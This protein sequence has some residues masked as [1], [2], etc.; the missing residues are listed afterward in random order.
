MLVVVPPDRA[1]LV[2]LEPVLGQ[3]IVG[4]A[5]ELVGHG[6]ARELWS[7]VVALD[8]AEAD[9]LVRIGNVAEALWIAEQA[10]QLR[11]C[12]SLIFR[13]SGRAGYG[14]LLPESEI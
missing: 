5:G 4:Q 9:A 1:R 13:Q 14:E 11:E 8:F 12:L 6:E 2:E 3:H 7:C 10:E